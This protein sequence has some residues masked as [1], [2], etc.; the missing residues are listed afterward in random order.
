MSDPSEERPSGDGFEAEV[1]AMLA[2]AGEAFR[3][4]PPALNR[5]RHDAAGG[6]RNGITVARSARDRIFQS[7]ATTMG[8]P[9]PSDIG[10]GP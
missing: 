4:E 6:R 8:G 3:R 7:D 1:G 5:A 10:S 2:G 9:P